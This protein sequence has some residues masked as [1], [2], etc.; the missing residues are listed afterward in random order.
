MATDI[1]VFRTFSPGD[2]WEVFGDLPSVVVNDLYVGG[3]GTQLYAGTYGRS[4]YTTYVG[5]L[6]VEEFTNTANILSVFPNPVSSE[7]TLVLER[8]VPDAEVTLYNQ[9]GQVVFTQKMEALTTTIS[10]QNLPK[11]MYF[12]QVKGNNEVFSRKLLKN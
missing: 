10:I 12:V 8:F 5:E 7:A 6:S 9:L 4:A 2:D 11:G 3:E 1:G